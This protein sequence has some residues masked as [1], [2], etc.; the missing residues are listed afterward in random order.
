MVRVDLKLLSISNLIHKL[1]LLGKINVIPA[2]VL[3]G[4]V[5]EELHLEGLLV[6][7]S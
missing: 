4:K 6:T 5:L 3:G 7:L 2:P 1:H